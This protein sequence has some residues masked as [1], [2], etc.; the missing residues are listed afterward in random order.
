M[1][2]ILLLLVSTLA[3]SGCSLS[4]KSD[5]ELAQTGNIPAQYRLSSELRTK[6]NIQEAN[7]WLIKAAHA[8]HTYAANNLAENYLYGEN[9]VEKNIDEAIRIYTETASSSVTPY[10]QQGV[11]TAQTKLA[12]MYESGE[13]I[14]QNQQEAFKWNL[15]LA[16]QNIRRSQIY[17]AKAYQAGNGVDKSIND[18][19]KWFK[20]SNS[21]LILGDIYLLGEGVDVDRK[22]AMDMYFQEIH[23]SGASD[24]DLA[25]AKS[26]LQNMDEYDEEFS[27]QISIVWSNHELFGRIITE[28][29]AVFESRKEAIVVVGAKVNNGN[30]R[31]SMNPANYWREYNYGEEL[32]LG[33]SDCSNVYKIEIETLNYGTV[34]FRI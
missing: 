28:Y 33:V 27:N 22:K 11:T 12:K 23:Y 10:Y 20:E 14:P 15:K 26:R 3:L 2:T 7:Y 29:K 5:L 9:G 16:K 8:G 4:P 34:S 31:V 21:F 32:V 25:V 24:S 6:G 17:V 30:C 13:E 19:I 18:A 1:R